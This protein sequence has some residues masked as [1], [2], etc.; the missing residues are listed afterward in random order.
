MSEAYNRPNSGYLVDCP[1]CEGEG[2]DAA[3]KSGL[4]ARCHGTGRMTWFL[5]ERIRARWSSK[6][7]G[8]RPASRTARDRIPEDAVPRDAVPDDDLRHIQ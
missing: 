3:A 4:C 2:T 1:Y 8:G 5:A 6:G 7:T